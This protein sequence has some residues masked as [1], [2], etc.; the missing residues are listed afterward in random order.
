MAYLESAVRLTVTLD[1]EV[2]AAYVYLHGSSERVGSATQHMLDEPRANGSIILDFDREGRLLG[3]EVLG[4]SN[5]L[6][7]SLLAAVVEDD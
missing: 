1:E 3:I 5:A 7:K 4:A 6:P 2:D